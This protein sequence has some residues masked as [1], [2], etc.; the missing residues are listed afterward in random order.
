[1]SHADD[2]TNI[3]WS[4]DTTNT[5][6]P[7]SFDHVQW[8]MNL[9]PNTDSDATG[10]EDA[11]IQLQSAGPVLRAALLPNGCGQTTAATSDATITPSSGGDDVSF[12]FTLQ[13][14]RSATGF[15]ATATQYQYRVTLMDADGWT[16]VVPSSS[17]FITHTL[18][19]S[20]ATATPTATPSPTPTPT[21]AGGTPTPSPTPTRTPTPTASHHSSSGTTTS[22][23]TPTAASGTLPTTGANVVVLAATAGALIYAGIELLGA[24]G[25]LESR[26]REP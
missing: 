2:S 15:P 14:F 11:C 19:G 25:R 8:D 5:V 22:D 10:P 26:Q 13:T 3:T 23:P 21:P 18:G 16:Y 4:F 20:G 12:S 1:V 17:A 7:G 24:K 9:N 6:T